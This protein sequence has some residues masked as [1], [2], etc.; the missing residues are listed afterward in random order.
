LEAE[1][2]LRVAADP[3]AI[4]Q[5]TRDEI[6]ILLADPQP[7]AWSFAEAARRTDEHTIACLFAHPE[8]EPEVL[9]SAIGSDVRR[10]E[11]FE[12]HAQVKA[13]MPKLSECLANLMPEPGPLPPLPARL[14]ERLEPH[15]APLC[16]Q[17]LIAGSETSNRASRTP[18]VSLSYRPLC[19]FLFLGDFLHYLGCPGLPYLGER[20]ILAKVALA[21]NP[22]QPLTPYRHDADLRVRRAARER[23]SW[24][25]P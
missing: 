12:W 24:H 22:L 15:L 13:K 3:A 11:R 7:P 10:L 23:M 25:E 14:R 19:P 20:P 18:R 6:C 5:L 4:S 21:L 8:A 17:A 16:R 1:L 9:E 2:L